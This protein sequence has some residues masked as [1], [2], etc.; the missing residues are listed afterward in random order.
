M[1]VGMAGRIVVLIEHPIFRPFRIIE[2]ATFDG[3]EKDQPNG[4]AHAQGEED[5]SEGRDGHQRTDLWREASSVGSEALSL[6]EFPTTHTEL[7]AMAAAAWI[8]AS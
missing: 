8:G 6:S 2:L 5:Q 4:C 7:R 1:I 3:P